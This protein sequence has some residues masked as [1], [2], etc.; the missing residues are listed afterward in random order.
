MITSIFLGMF[1]VAIIMFILA[2]YEDSMLF[3]SVSLLFWFALFA[4]SM[5]LQIPYVYSGTEYTRTMQDMTV[6]IVILGMLIITIIMLIS[7]IFSH[8]LNKRY[9][10]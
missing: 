5:G 9:R 10:L 2:Y 6:N 3:T 7:Q 8:S 4:A 1:I